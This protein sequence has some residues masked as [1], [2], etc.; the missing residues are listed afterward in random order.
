M[1]TNHATKQP[2]HDVYSAEDISFLGHTMRAAISRGISR[3]ETAMR[4][5]AKRDDRPFLAI[6]RGIPGGTNPDAATKV[7][8]QDGCG[9]LFPG[10]NGEADI[11]KRDRSRIQFAWFSRFA[12]RLLLLKRR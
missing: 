4:N 3:R 1:S 5:I 8:E 11:S 10:K 2:G 7:S 9:D 6:S 12:A